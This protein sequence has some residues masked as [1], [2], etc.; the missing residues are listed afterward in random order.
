MLKSFLDL[1]AQLLIGEV[2]RNEVTYFP[3]YLFLFCYYSPKYSMFYLGTEIESKLK[4]S[5]STRKGKA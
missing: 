1:R 3:V 5:M 2:L 4:C